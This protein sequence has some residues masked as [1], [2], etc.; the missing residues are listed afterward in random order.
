MRL[1]ARVLV[2]LKSM[3]SSTWERPAPSQSPSSTLPARHHACALTT[4]ALWSSRRMICRPLSSVT[5][6]TPGGTN[7]M[8]G[9]G[10]GADW[11]LDVFKAGGR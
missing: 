1:P 5:K 8:T 9:A 11:K 3:C 10:A 2:P 7:G 4:G 6:R